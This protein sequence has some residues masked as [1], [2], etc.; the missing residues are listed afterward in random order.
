MDIKVI[1]HINK[2]PDVVDDIYLHF[3]C[4]NPQMYMII[5]DRVLSDIILG[6]RM[7]TKTILVE[8]FN[9]KHDN[10]IVKIIRRF[11]SK[12]IK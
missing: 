2:K 8:P 12:L 11:E 7:G 5:G 4:N 9:V 10:F 6:N 1:R 3:G